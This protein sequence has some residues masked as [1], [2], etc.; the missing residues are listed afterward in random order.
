MLHVNTTFTQFTTHTH[1][2]YSHLTRT[3]Q[4]PER[5]HRKWRMLIGLRGHVTVDA[6]KRPQLGCSRAFSYTLIVIFLIESVPNKKLS[7]SRSVQVSKFVLNVMTL[8]F[9]PSLFL[10]SV[11][12]QQHRPGLLLTSG[13]LRFRALQPARQWKLY[14]CH[15]T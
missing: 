9:P 10:A 14:S 7:I 12:V 4:L 8:L 2:Q 15:W 11:S 6:Q 5:V 3:T 1:T 13:T